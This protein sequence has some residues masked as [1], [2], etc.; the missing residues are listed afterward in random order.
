MENIEISERSMNLWAVLLQKA[1][2]N[3]TDINPYWY[4]FDPIGV[5]NGAVFGAF[6]ALISVASLIG[7]FIIAAHSFK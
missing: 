7:N 2:L 3:V 4:Q 1:A 6:I 5:K